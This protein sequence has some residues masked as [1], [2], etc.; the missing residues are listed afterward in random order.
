M[1]EP[2]DLS[3]LEARRAIGQRKLSPVELLESCLARIAATNGA[4]NADGGDGRGR[5]APTCPRDRGRHRPWRGGGAAGR[6]ADWHQGPQHNRRAP[7]HVRLAAVQGP[8]AAQ[9]R[10]RRGAHP[11]RRRRDPGQD[12]HARVR[13]R[14]QHGE[15]GVRRHR[16]SVRP[17]QDL[18]GL[19]RRLG[20]GGGSGPGPARHRLGLR[21]Q[22]AHARRLLRRRRL[23]AFARPG[24]GYRPGGEPQS[25][26][27][28][29]PHG[30]HHRRR[31]PAAARA[32]GPSI[33]AIRSPRAPARLSLPSS[34]APTSARCASPSRPISA[35]RRSI[36][37][38]PP[39]SRS[40]SAASVI[41][42]ARWR[43]ALRTSAACTRCSRRCAG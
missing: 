26:L 35:A 28:R 31:A 32:G 7:D 5:R 25:V 4:V 16:Q 23:P 12:Q 2:C 17:G 39:S 38:L 21:R 14:R 11:Q 27:R 18:L 42:S 1:A 15:P 43:S 19:L 22:P 34:P 9:G 20:R 36:A 33:E 24:A 3:A 13:R 29:G 41:S 30:P 10:R 40:A 6:A 8:R 37:A